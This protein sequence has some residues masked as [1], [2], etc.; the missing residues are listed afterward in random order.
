MSVT[1][2]AKDRAALFATADPTNE[3]QNQ[4]EYESDESEDFSNSDDEG[5]S[6][7]R[8]GGYHPVYTG[9]VYNDRYTVVKKL[10]WGHFSTVWLAVDSAVPETDPNKLVAL[11]IQKSASQY[12]EAAEDEI[13]LLWAARTSKGAAKKFVV[14]LLNHFVFHGPNGK[15]VCMVFE[16]M[17]KNILSLI[18]KYDYRGIPLELTKRITYQILIGLDYLHRRCKI[19]H[20]DLK[21]ENFLLCLPHE[22]DIARLISDAK[23]LRTKRLRERL[24]KG[25]P[26]YTSKRNNESSSAKPASGKHGKK[27]ERKP[28]PGIDENDVK[29]EAAESEEGKR[30]AKMVYTKISDLGNAC[31]VDKHFTDDITTRQYRSPEVIVGSPYDTSTD[32]WSIACI[33]FELVTGDYLFD[34]KE[35]EY[36]HHSRDEDHLALIIELLGSMPKTLTRDGKYSRQFFNSNGQLRN[37]QQLD[38]WG[39]KDVLLEKYKLKRKDAEQLSAF[40]LPMLTLEPSKRC[41]CFEALQNPFLDDVRGD[42][43]SQDIDKELADLLAKRLKMSSEQKKKEPKGRKK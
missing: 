18:K 21:P 43:P 25:L 37:I 11:K 6:A 29:K 35:D 42:Y 39:L 30:R 27:K 14:N 13:T 7:Y 40:L 20:T 9:D 19:I 15:H 3:K 23:K 33:V 10:G 38:S 32:I 12:T 36:G 41:T 34:P 28:E 16:V 1:A 8:K 2:K 17:G 26:S 24:T 22:L 31:W 4:S 5:K